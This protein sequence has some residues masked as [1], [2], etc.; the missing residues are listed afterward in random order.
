VLLLSGRQLLATA[1]DNPAA[2]PAHRTIEDHHRDICEE[3]RRLLASIGPLSPAVAEGKGIADGL[4]LATARH[5]TG[6]NRDPWQADIGNARGVIGN[7]RG[8][9]GWMPLAKSGRRGF[10]SYLS[11]RAY[12]VPFYLRD[13]PRMHAV[14]AFAEPVPG[15]F[16]L[17][18]GRHIGLGV[19]AAMLS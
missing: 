17:G 5:D 15:P 6:K 12:R 11:A 10:V 4:V 2:A 18:A 16:A 3:I 19:F 7:A 13:F 9:D 8:V 1:E 14:I